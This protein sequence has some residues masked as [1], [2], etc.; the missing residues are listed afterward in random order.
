MPVIET[1]GTATEGLKL[2]VEVGRALR[3]AVGLRFS[4]DGFRTLS[5]LSTL[6][7]EYEGGRADPHYVQDRT[8]VFTKRGSLAA[9]HFCNRKGRTSSMSC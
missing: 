5:T 9:L 1:I 7:F 2:L 3:A 6:E 8:I 4:K